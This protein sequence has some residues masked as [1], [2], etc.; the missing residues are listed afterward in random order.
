MSVVHYHGGPIWGGDENIKALYEKGGALV[1]FRRPDQIKKIARLKCSLVLDNGAFS[2]WRANQ[3]EI[4][5]NFDWYAHWTSYYTFVLK[6]IGRIDWFI[7]PDVIEGSEKEN[8]LLVSRVPSALKSK[9]VPVWHSDE[10]ISRLLR[11]SN[12]FAL[13]AVGCCGE[14]TKIRSEKWKVRM[15][16]VFYEVYIKRNLKVK[17]H[18]LRMLD[19]RVLSNYPFYSADS[20]NVAINVP[21]TQARLPSVTCKLART[22]IMRHTIEM[23]KPPTI[24]EYVEKIHMLKSEE[25]QLDLFEDI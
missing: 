7:I 11:L 25:K 9:A 15:D 12:D 6:W 8:D 17:L 3:K 22:A 2:T 19:G 23:I 20:T 10:S 14:H 16:E 24:K 1:S 4:E 5:N 13:V 18:G 21:K